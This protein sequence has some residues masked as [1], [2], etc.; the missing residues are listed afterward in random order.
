MTIS[1]SVITGFARR[2][3]RAEMLAIL[4]WLCVIPCYLITGLTTFTFIWIG[5]GG[6]LGLADDGLSWFSIVIVM[7]AAF[8]AVRAS[9][10]TAPRFKL[11]VAILGALASL[12]LVPSLYTLETTSDGE[13]I[14][15]SYELAGVIL[16]S[17][18]AFVLI[19][20]RAKRAQKV[21]S[22]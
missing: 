4:R 15:S 17:A 18:L 13:A 14:P 5:L 9:A 6:P 16:G 22:S 8:A 11:I 1:S 21:T 10:L 12:W 20:I 2:P 7:G 3:N 19:F